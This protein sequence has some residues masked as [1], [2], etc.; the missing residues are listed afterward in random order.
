VT[1]L[2]GTQLGQTQVRVP[3][4]C[5]GTGS[6]RGLYRDVSDAEAVETI[7]YALEHQI[8]MIDTAPWY[9]A[10]E[11]ERIV[12]LALAQRPRDSYVLSTKACLWS[13][14]NEAV[15]GYTRDLVLWSL[16]GSLKRLG[17]DYVDML[18]IHDPVGE[19]FATILDETIPTFL[20]LRSQG[21]IRAIG[22]GTGD[23]RILERLSREFTFDCVM[24]AGRYTLLEQEAYPLINDLSQH[25]TAVFS[26]GIYNSGI[27][28]TG[29][30]ADA[31]YNYSNAPTAVLEHVVRLAHVCQRH[32]VALKTA[33][34]QFVRAN[35]AIVT[36]IFGAETAAQ[37]AENV[38]ILN[39]PLPA[40]LW[41]DLRAE[42][43]I[44]LDAPTPKAAP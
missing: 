1:E 21:V 15:R 36:I 25:G 28:A 33:A 40:A 24:I 23:W 10:F 13:E 39:M 37:L 44:P 16:E 2:F 7:S 29:A 30:S 20:D 31:K 4:L 26:A 32:G 43:L 38:D 3:D 19:H 34:A 17:L 12:G 9:G 8:T 42:R 11:A 6:F 22:C 14:N 27:L 18:H 5:L 41:D 35:P